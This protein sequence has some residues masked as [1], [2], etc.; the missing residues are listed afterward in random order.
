MGSVLGCRNTGFLLNFKV[1]FFGFEK[2]KSI[3]KL[4]SFFLVN[5]QAKN[6][7]CLFDSKCYISTG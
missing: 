7:K 4:A 6:R 2:A 1:L 3:V 5:A